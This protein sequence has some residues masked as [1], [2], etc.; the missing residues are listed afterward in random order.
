[1]NV[2]RVEITFPVTVDLGKHAQRLTQVV[3]E[4][5]KENTPKGMVMWPSEVGYKMTYMPMT[6]E[7]EKHR[8]CEFDEDVFEIRC[9]MRAD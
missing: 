4:I 5:C 8:G 1:M 2:M 7:E 6:Q 9:F 3:S